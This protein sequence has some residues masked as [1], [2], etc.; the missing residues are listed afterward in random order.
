M[1]QAHLAKR[2]DISTS[3]LSRILQGADPG[4]DA[5]IRLA[6]EVGADLI[7]LATGRGSPNAA[8]SGYLSV[9]IYDVRLAAGV[10]AFADAAEVI[11][12]MP[13]DRGLLRDIG[14]TTADG[15][16]VFIAEG[17]SMHPKIADGARVLTDLKD[18]RLREGV[19]AFR[20]GDELRIK[21]LR[22]RLDGI[23]IISDNEN[24]PPEL[25][26]GDAADDLAIIGKV[27]W[28][29]TVV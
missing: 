12:E 21:R 24:Y 5:S 1:Q 9:P 2:A 19:F 3:T 15:L 20:T 27:L 17:D 16:A 25:V 18:V 29:G 4:L 8:A 13:F 22:R 10:A 14:R 26:T 23:E 28:T 11:G 7:W 6:R